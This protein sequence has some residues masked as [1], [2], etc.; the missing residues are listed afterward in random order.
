MCICV[1]RLLVE[2][3]YEVEDVVE[4]IICKVGFGGRGSCDCFRRYVCKF[5]I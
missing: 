1:Y 5:C 2:I 3:V 4:N